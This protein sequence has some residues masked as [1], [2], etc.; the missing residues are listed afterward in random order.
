MDNKEIN[1]NDLVI[2]NFTTI[3]PITFSNT[4]FYQFT[5]AV[6]PKNIPGGG[7]EMEV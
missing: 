1:R 7:G 4:I 5:F 6:P 3:S 2:F